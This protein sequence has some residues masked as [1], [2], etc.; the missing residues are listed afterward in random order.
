[1]RHH[2]TT[3]CLRNLQWVPELFEF[4]QKIKFCKLGVPSPEKV[5]LAAQTAATRGPRIPGQAA[6]SRR[7][8]S[9]GTAALNGLFQPL[10]TP[11][12]THGLRKHCLPLAPA[13]LGREC[14]SAS[15]AFASWS[16]LQS[17]GSPPPRPSSLHVVPTLL[18]WARP[19]HCL[20]LLPVCACLQ[21]QSL[22]GPLAH[23]LIASLALCRPCGCSGKLETGDVGSG[24]TR[25]K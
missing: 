4:E 20:E 25:S 8:T 6:S 12:R 24:E 13:T 22:L 5:P 15:M 9:A 18:G 17:F 11:L 1:M 23:L 3:A 21:P 10:W 2:R 16:F 7:L 19:P 14:P